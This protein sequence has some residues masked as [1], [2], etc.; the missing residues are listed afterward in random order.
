LNLTIL[1]RF[2]ISKQQALIL[3]LRELL[4]IVIILI[5]LVIVLWES[6]ILA[7]F[8]LNGTL[9]NVDAARATC[10]ILK[11]FAVSIILF[12]L[13]VLDLTLK[14][15]ELIAENILVLGLIMI[16]IVLIKHRRRATQ[17]I[18]DLLFTHGKCLLLD[19]YFIVAIA[20]HW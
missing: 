13:H 4:L 10:R 17:L 3:I 12:F 19:L 6:T 2:L 1:R 11:L 5:V 8:F 16:R 9:L 18:L 15:L 7:R 14:C 20:V